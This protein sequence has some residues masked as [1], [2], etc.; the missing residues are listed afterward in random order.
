MTKLKTNPRIE[1][2]DEFYKALADLHEGKS[3]E[4]SLLIN[5]KLILLL[6]NHIG[7][8][9]VLMAAIKAVI[10]EQ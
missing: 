4:E 2:P 10:S 9:E 7:E 6:A 5:S 1:N 8:H 3:A